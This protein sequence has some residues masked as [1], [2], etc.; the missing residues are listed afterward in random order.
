MII[1]TKKYENQDTIIDQKCQFHLGTLIRKK[2]GF[3]IEYNPDIVLVKSVDPIL[4][5]EHYSELTSE[6]KD[7]YAV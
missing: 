3:S 2:I 4:F 7:I 6:C 1:N 5:K